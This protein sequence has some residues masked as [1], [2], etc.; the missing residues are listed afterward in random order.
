M[1]LE[2]FH[3]DRKPFELSPDP[4]LFFGSF[5]HRLA[6]SMLEYAVVTGTDLCLVTGEVGSGKTTL[7]QCLLQRVASNTSVGVVSN[8]HRAFGDLLDLILG[9]FD[10]DEST[11]GAAQKYRAFV[12][13]I[14]AQR[15]R[16]RRVVLIVDEAQNLSSDDLEA[17]RV[18]TNV[19]ASGTKVL[20]IVL[21]GQ[22]ELREKLKQRELRQLVQ[23]IPVDFD[24]KPLTQ[25]DVVCYVLHRIRLC[26]GAEGLFTGSALEAVCRHAHGVPRVINLL[27]DLA[28]VFAFAE[29]NARV[30]ETIVEDVVREKSAEGLFWFEPQHYRR[31]S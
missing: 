7:V 19:N 8:T 10:I 29:G 18:L 6:L 11:G 3:L 27:C 21:I 1:Y 13:F 12:R 14:D 17:I 30:T 15:A 2:H 25:R 9:A 5:S 28:L 31:E 23:R 26:G 20:Q 4:E 24:L 22:P 16:Q